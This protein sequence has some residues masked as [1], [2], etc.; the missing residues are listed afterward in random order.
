MSDS[1][2]GIP[3]ELRALARSIWWLVLIRGILAVVFGVLALALPTVALLALV[4]TFAAYAIVDGVA[5]IA[6]SFRVRGQDARWGWLLAQGIVSVIAGIVAFIFPLT[7]GFVFGLWAL[8]IIGIYAIM[9]GIS[10]IPA[11]AS[12][13]AGGSRVLG[14]VLAILSIVAGIVI[15]IVAVV[16]PLAGILNLIW[17]VGVY[18]IIFG[19]LLIV[20]SIQARRV[21]ARVGAA[22][23]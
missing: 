1:A 3:V 2:S 12:I 9:M 21:T 16:S 20:L 7:A 11:S 19:V 22:A 10:G 17:L 5:N 15:L 6:H 18:A 13:A 23:V 8:V 4:F 14:Y